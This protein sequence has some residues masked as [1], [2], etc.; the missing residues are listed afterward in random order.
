MN[1]VDRIP[2]SVGGTNLLAGL[3]MAVDEIRR[4]SVHKLNLISE[5]LSYSTSGVERVSD[6]SW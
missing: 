6:G 4:Y 2:Y 5:Y 1:A 3:E